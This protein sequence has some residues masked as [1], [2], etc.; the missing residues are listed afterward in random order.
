MFTGS[1]EANGLL[2]SFARY[3]ASV[4]GP[5]LQLVDVTAKSV[6]L[7]VETINNV[8]YINEATLMFSTVLSEAMSAKIN[9]ETL[10]SSLKL[11]VDPLLSVFNNLILGCEFKNAEDELVTLQSMLEC[12]LRVARVADWSQLVA[13]HLATPGLILTKLKS[14]E[15]FQLCLGP[16]FAAFFHLTQKLKSFKK[17]DKLFAESVELEAV[18]QSWVRCFQAKCHSDFAPKYFKIVQK[19]E[20]ASQMFW[21]LLSPKEEKANSKTEDAENEMGPPKAKC[22]CLLDKTKLKEVDQMLANVSSALENND[23]S[24]VH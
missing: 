18:L 21:A 12:C 15:E 14:L 2:F 20:T 1:T 17:W 11:Q 23:V 24:C 19:D 13:S 3:L 10:M 22:L 8:R 5:S 4:H 9:D 7:Y 6:L 16:I